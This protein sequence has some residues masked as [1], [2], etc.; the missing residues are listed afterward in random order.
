MAT[1]EKPAVPNEATSSPREVSILCDPEGFSWLE[2]GERMDQKTFH[3]RYLKTPAGF[4]AEL[5][6]GVVYIMAS[7]LKNDHGRSDARASAW[8]FFYSMETPGTEAQNNTTTILGRD[9]EPQP[10]S[11]LL[12][13]PQYGGQSRE[14]SDD[15]THGAPE[16]I[17]ETALS[18]RSIDLSEKL[19]D[20]E[21]AGV[22]EYVVIQ[23]RERAVLWFVWRDGRFEPVLPDPD[24]LHRS[25]T[26]PGLWLDADALLRNDK[27]ALIAMLQRGLATPEHAAFVAALERRRTAR[28]E[29]P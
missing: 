25:R 16:L 15:F 21:R 19:R 4:Q 17:V 22:R 13:L 20:Y 29:N 23:L 12:I 18:S 11:T 5:I 7:P 26:F 9:S 1:V 10:D 6:G 8:L 2:N 14:S 28:R 3:E 27:R 24:G